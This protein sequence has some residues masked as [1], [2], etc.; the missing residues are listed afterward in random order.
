MADTPTWD[1]DSDARA[2]PIVNEARNILTYRGLVRLL[3]VRD[4]TVRYK[5][6]VLGV[7]WTVLNPVF[8]ALV[9]YVVFSNVFR[10]QLPGGEPFVVYLL[11][12][13]AYMTFFSQGL[14]AVGNSMI[15][16]SGLI[17]KVR[18]PPECFAAAAACASAV[19]FVINL[20]PLL[21]AQLITGTGIPLS[22]LLI[23][24]PAVS[25]ML[26]IMGLGMLVATVAIRF[27]DALEV[28]GIVVLGVFYLTPVFYPSDI[29][30]SRFALFLQLN[31]LT[32]YLAVFRQLMYGG[33]PASLADWLIMLTTSLA[34]VAGGTYVFSRRWPSL[35]AML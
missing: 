30:P 22:I 21:A 14:Q 19:T 24:V 1:Y 15:A 33:A 18:V 26:L 31:P 6:S 35:A 16:S 9:L 10:S 27:A 25:L 5:R 20:G 23:P 17:G 32:H 28:V 7:W 3:T 4:L 8:T 2:A 29:V 13:V 11:S 12:G 34:A